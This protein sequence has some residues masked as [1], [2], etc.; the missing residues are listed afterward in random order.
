[1]AYAEN[2]TYGVYQAG[3]DKLVLCDSLADQVMQAAGI[4]TYAR[5]QDIDPGTLTCKHPLAEQ[6]YDFDVPLLAGDFV[7]DETG[8]GLVHIAR[9]WSGRF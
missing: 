8:T 1:M 6:G 4:E 3:D 9:P 5:L 7:T 2:L